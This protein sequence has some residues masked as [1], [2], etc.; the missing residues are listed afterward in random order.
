MWPRTCAIAEVLWTGDARP[1]F[2]DFKRRIV[3]HRRRL[4]SRGVNCANLK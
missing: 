2:D 4:V 3:L 1:G